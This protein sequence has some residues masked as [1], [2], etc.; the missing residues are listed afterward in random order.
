MRDSRLSRLSY[1][2]ASP[3]LEQAAFEMYVYVMCILAVVVE[4]W[5]AASGTVGKLAVYGELRPR[6]RLAGFAPRDG[7]RSRA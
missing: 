3:I 6:P 4:A 7:A 5:A 2:K 1:I